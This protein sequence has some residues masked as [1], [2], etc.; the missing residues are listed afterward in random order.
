MSP[1]TKEI[2]F[3]YREEL[4][5]IAALE[6][7]GLLSGARLERRRTERQPG[8]QLGSRSLFATMGYPMILCRDVQS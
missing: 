1:P 5:A 8:S 3:S 7:K 2:K 6:D 4:K